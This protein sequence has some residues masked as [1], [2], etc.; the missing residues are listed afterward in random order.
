[1]ALAQLDQ[2]ALQG[3]ILVRADGAGATHELCDYCREGQL[4]FSVGSGLTEP[5]YEAIVNTPEHAWELAL[6]PDG[7]RL[8]EHSWVTEIT[9]QVDLS[10]WPQSSRLIARRTLLTEGD[11]QSFADHDGYRLCVF[12]TDQTDPDIRRLDLTHRGHARVEDHIREA[13]DCGMRNLPFRAFSHNEVW[14]WLVGLAQDLIAWARQLC[15][16]HDARRWEVK[17][18]RYRLLHQSGRLTRHARKTILRLSRP[19]PWAGLLTTAFARLK[20]LPAAS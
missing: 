7:K 9:S 18:L 15:L 20:A 5:V 16:R 11:Q 4:Q 3:G 2:T 12:L 19:W 10:G 17:K 6:R 14:L 1:M 13:K 8:R